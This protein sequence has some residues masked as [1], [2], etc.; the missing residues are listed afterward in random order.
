VNTAEAV[1]LLAHCAAFDN[2]KPS[3]A[4]AQA[5]AAALQDVPLDADTL[6]AV[7]RYYGTPDTDGDAGGQKFIQPHHIRTHR[8][9]LREERLGPPGPG[10]SPEIPAADPDDVQGYLRALREQRARAAAGQQVPALPPGDTD[11]AEHPD[12]KA[13][14]EKFEQAKAEARR[15]KVEQARA[16]SEALAAYRQAVETLLAQP[17]HGQAAIQQARAELYGPEQAAQGFP[18]AAKTP[19]VC[20]EHKTYIRAAQIASQGQR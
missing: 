2:R 12:A 20:D 8:K 19:G 4:A 15:R 18:E 13:I 3:R 17:D 9:A 14:R 1:Q 5:W 11:A 6:A 16:E 10:L 7:A